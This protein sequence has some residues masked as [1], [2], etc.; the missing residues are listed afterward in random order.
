MINISRKFHLQ[1]GS[2]FTMSALLFLVAAFTSCETDP[3]SPPQPPAGACDSCFA[4]KSCKQVLGVWYCIEP[5]CTDCNPPFKKCVMGQCVP[6]NECTCPEGQYCVATSGGP[7]CQIPSN[8]CVPNDPTPGAAESCD[9]L[10]GKPNG[11]TCLPTSS[12]GASCQCENG[13]VIAQCGP[14]NSGGQGVCVQPCNG[15]SGQRDR[16]TCNCI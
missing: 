14:L 15:G 10:A 8:P 2:F 7:H 6:N 16:S 12:G 13:Y 1:A 9:D 4:P 3:T 11:S 5:G